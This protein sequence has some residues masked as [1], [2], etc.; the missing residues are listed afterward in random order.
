MPRKAATSSAPAPPA[1]R[2]RTRPAVVRLSGPAVPTG[3]SAA[4]IEATSRYIDGAF[5]CYESFNRIKDDNGDLARRGFALV[6]SETGDA[7][8]LPFPDH[9]PLGR[10]GA[11][12]RHRDCLHPDLD[13]GLRVGDHVT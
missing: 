1:H 12:R 6:L 7:L 5:R 11:S 4:A 8:L 13:G 3:D 2:P 9:V 10:L